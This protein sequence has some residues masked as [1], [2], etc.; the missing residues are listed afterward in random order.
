MT[1][2]LQVAF[3]EVAQSIVLGRKIQSG[4]RDAFLKF[5]KVLFVV[6]DIIISFLS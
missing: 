3:N 1:D 4:E 6:D 5:S 2:Q